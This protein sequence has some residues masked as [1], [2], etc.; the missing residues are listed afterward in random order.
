[1]DGTID[2][3][4]LPFSVHDP[5]A[6]AD[7]SEKSSM[8]SDMTTVGDVYPVIDARAVPDVITL[9]TSPSLNTLAE[10]VSVIPVPVIA[11][12]VSVASG[13]LPTSD[14][15]GGRKLI[16]ANVQSVSSTLESL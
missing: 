4:G 16:A 14:V 1:M 5:E 7:V 9:P 3:V 12:G 15:G 2:A 10:A 8:T 11:E 13:L 6:M